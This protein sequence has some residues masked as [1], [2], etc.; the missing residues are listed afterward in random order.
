MD[1]RKSRTVEGKTYE[2]SSIQT[3]KSGKTNI[4]STKDEDRLMN[5]KPLVVGIILFSFSSLFM[6]RG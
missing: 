3:I 4:S 1:G 6:S 5:G 2:F